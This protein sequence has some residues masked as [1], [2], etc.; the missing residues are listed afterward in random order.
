MQSKENFKKH[1][2]EPLSIDD[3][4]FEQTYD[5]K[6]PSK[7]DTHCSRI[8]SIFSKRWHP[9]T[10]RNEYE[11]TFS[12]INWNALEEK[13][14]KLHTVSKCMMCYNMH[15]DLQCTFPAQPVH[16]MEPEIITSV[17]T[18]RD[19]FIKTVT[20]SADRVCIPKFGQTFIETLIK[21]KKVDKHKD[22]VENRRLKREL[23]RKC[24]D[25]SNDVLHK[26]PY[27][28]YRCGN[29]SPLLLLQAK[30]R[31]ICLTPTPVIT[32]PRH[33]IHNYIIIA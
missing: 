27:A 5:K 24:R 4:Y 1:F 13:E 3:K 31:P 17:N 22:K 19:T 14:K 15:Y 12:L 21:T 6:M 20:A 16:K 33:T 32:I 29:T 11:S 18:S 2:Q 9:Q 30:P 10:K 28:K 7:Y 26:M 23:L 25:E 8:K